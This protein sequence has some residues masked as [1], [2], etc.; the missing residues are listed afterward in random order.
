MKHLLLSVSIVSA[1]TLCTA[2]ETI[3]APIDC[4]DAQSVLQQYAKVGT[5][6]PLMVLDNTAGHQVL[7]I[8]DMSDNDVHVWV[9]LGDK[10]CFI[11]RGTLKTLKIPTEKRTEGPK[12]LGN[13]LM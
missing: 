1:C 9:Y 10:M 5:W 7:L 11:D 3:Q 13:G 12:W 2:K 4:Y 6:E 8:R